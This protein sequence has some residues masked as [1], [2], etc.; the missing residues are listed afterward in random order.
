[1]FTAARMGN[2]L[3]FDYMAQRTNGIDG[4]AQ[5][6]GMYSPLAIV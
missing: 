6:R 5:R 4:R 2:Q 3:H 1:M